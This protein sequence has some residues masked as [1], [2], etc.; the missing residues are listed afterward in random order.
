MTVLSLAVV[1]CGGAEQSSDTTTVI[2][3]VESSEA[4]LATSVSE[5]SVTASTEVVETVADSE[6]STPSSE[7]TAV[8]APATSA[9]APSTGDSTSATLQDYID[10]L[11]SSTDNFDDLTSTQEETTCAATAILTPIG[12]ERLQQEGV[13]VEGVNQEL[14]L[15]E[16]VTVESAADIADGLIACGVGIRFAASLAQGQATGDLDDVEQAE[17][18][19]CV[20]SAL[21][22]DSA[23]DSLTGFL[24][25]EN[26]S[27]PTLE[28][29]RYTAG[30]FLSGL[31]RDCGF[32]ATVYP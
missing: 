5:S 1:G 19:E 12:V 22:E 23:R 28:P 24:S 17:L 25:P 9:S 18:L 11:A 21:D 31:V 27:D 30:V 16:M 2:T 15:T 14:D 7:A 26:A 10:S 4:T 8:T 6:P 29:S 32:D 3:I 20:S 13:S